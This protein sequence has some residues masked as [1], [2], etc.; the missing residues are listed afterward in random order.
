VPNSVY[1]SSSLDEVMGI[2]GVHA[3]VRIFVE[4]LC[5]IFV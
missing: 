2:V 5:I 4:F 1:G 3:R